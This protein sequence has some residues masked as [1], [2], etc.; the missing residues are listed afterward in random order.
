[1]S[2]SATGGCRV[3]ENVYLSEEQEKIV[4]SLLW[5]CDLS[6]EDFYQV[7]KGKKEKAGFFTREKAVKRLLEYQNWYNV[8][9]VLSLPEIGSVWNEGLRAS[10]RGKQIAEGI[11]F[12]VRI[13][14]KKTLPISR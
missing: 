12:A 1:M 6:P 7:L 5:D 13:L 3:S 2:V 9:K 8:L 11:D 14:R 4:K 10:I